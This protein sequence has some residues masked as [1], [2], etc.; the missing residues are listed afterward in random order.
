MTDDS[1]E[2]FFFESGTTPFG[3][4]FC[5]NETTKRIDER[6]LVFICQMSFRTD[7]QSRHSQSQSCDSGFS[8]F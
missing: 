6:D 4:T 1:G 2:F 5:L 3:A 8:L 7:G